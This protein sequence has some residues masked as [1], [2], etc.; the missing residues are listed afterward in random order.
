MER[1]WTLKYLEQNGITELTPPFKEGPGGS[2]LVRADD[3][4]WCS[5]CWARKTC[6]AARACGAA[7]RGDEITLDVHGTVIERLDDPNDASDD[8]PVDDEDEDDEDR[9]RPDRHRRG[10]ERAEAAPERR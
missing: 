7:G 8:G 1:F 4:R 5:P 9:G 3:F 10:C 6:R 2:F